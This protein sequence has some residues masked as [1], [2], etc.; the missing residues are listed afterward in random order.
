MYKMYAV[1]LLISFS[2]SGMEKPPAPAVPVPKEITSPTLAGIPDRAKLELLIKIADDHFRTE[3]GTLQMAVR[4]MR[5]LFFTCKAY[6]KFMYDDDATGW[7]IAHLVPVAN[8]RWHHLNTRANYPAIDASVALC[9]VSAGRDLVRRL[10]LEGN[11]EKLLKENRKAGEDIFWHYLDDGTLSSKVRIAHLKMLYNAGCYP[12]HGTLGATPLMV[13][14]CRPDTVLAEFLFERGVDLSLDT[15]NS[16][17]AEDVLKRCKEKATQEKNQQKI[18]DLRTIENMLLAYK[19][20][21]TQKT[22]LP[23]KTESNKCIIS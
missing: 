6:A 8:K 15:I 11:D 19:A 23:R 4:D 14:I 20:N 1:S 10:N 17:T 7:I 22:N 21:L 13:A 18:E 12:Q 9:T 3:N 16:E 5:S 2:I